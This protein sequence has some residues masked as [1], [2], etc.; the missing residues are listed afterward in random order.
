MIET[1]LNHIMSCKNLGEEELNTQYSG[2]ENYSIFYFRNVPYLT[3]ET[4][5]YSAK[6]NNYQEGLEIIARYFK[7][8]SIEIESKILYKEHLNLDKDIYIFYLRVLGS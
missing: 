5:N 8:S 1:H 3:G 4:A 6:I 7:K 2:K